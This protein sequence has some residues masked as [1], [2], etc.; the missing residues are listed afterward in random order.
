MPELREAQ[1]RHRR[2]REVLRGMAVYDLALAL[3]IDR[4]ECNDLGLCWN[5][6]R[7]HVNRAVS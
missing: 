4:L 3:A 5:D 7:E 2:L 1:V 6:V